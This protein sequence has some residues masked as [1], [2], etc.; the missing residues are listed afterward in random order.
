MPVVVEPSRV[1]AF[2]DSDAFTT[3]LRA[4]HDTETE[5]WLKMHKVGSGLPSIDWPQ[6][7]DVALCWGWIDGI[8]KSV[9]GVSF[10]QRFTPRGKKSMWSQKNVDNVARLIA[11]GRMTEHGMVHVDAAQ[12]DGRWA[13]AYGSGKG[14]PVP[15][16]LQTAIDA[17]PAAKE[18]FALLTEQNRFALAFRTHNIKTDAAR[19]KKI[20]AFVSMLS[21]GETLYPQSTSA[22]KKT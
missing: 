17:V 7:V 8:R 14:M 11:A 1:H 18:M 6:A 22:N 4:H 10:V 21:R 19:Q 20:A 5:L 3:W 13:R 16:D 12:A 9:D 2:V 15:S